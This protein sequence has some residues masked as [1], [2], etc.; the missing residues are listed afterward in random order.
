METRFSSGRRGGEIQEIELPRQ[1]IKFRIEKGLL[2]CSS[3]PY[4]G[5]KME[6]DP[7]AFGVV[8]LPSYLLLSPPQDAAKP[9]KLL[10]PQ[11]G[12]NYLDI[13]P[14]PLLG[15]TELGYFQKWVLSK[16]LPINQQTPK[17]YWT[18]SR[19]DAS[20]WTV[21]VE[22]GKSPWEGDVDPRA[23]LNAAIYAL[24]HSQVDGAAATLLVKQL[25][26][27]LQSMDPSDIDQGVISSTSVEINKIA[28]SAS[29]VIS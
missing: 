5:Y 28:T 6:T 25:V 20:F 8:G 14:S 16:I 7:N 9:S 1:N 18:S 23:I 19:T 3:P 4:E 13:F 22:K 17:Y 10:I 27:R 12:G 11:F 26:D 15:A 24:H 21:D 2:I 29:L